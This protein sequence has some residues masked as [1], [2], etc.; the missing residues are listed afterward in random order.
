MESFA[1]IKI[2]TNETYNMTPPDSASAADSSFGSLGW[3]VVAIIVAV[4][5]VAVVKWRVLS[6]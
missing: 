5:V 2:S 1:F 3:W 4:M 6:G